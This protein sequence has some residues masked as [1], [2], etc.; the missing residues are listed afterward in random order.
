MS[1]ST[2]N[3]GPVIDGQNRLRQDFKTFAQQWAATKEDWRD[4]RRE[5]FERE[6]LLILGPS[7]ARLSAVLDEFREFVTKSDRELKDSIPD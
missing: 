4:G 3:L 7:L 6:H 5:L 1:E 2:A